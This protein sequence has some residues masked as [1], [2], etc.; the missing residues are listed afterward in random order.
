MTE[1]SFI[2]FALPGHEGQ[3]VLHVQGY[4]WDKRIPTELTDQL[5]AQLPEWRIDNRGTL[6]VI[7]HQGNMGHRDDLRVVPAVE[8]VFGK[9]DASA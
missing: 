9:V 3:Y 8:H 1:I 4:G 5:Q 2:R 7:E 6:V